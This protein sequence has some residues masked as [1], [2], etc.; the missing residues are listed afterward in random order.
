MNVALVYDRVNKWGGAERVLLALHK[1]WPKA[2]L[3]T[4]VYDPIRAPW[5]DVF[6]VRPSFLQKIPGAT[7]LHE[8]L[9]GL[10]PLAFESFRFD[11]YDVVVSVTSA[12]A[13]DILTKPHTTHIC[14]CLTPTRYLW[15]GFEHYK[16]R[17]GLGRLSVGASLGLKILGPT[18]REW[19]GIAA[20]RPDHYIAISERVKNRI[21]RYY[22]RDTAAVVHPPVDLRRFALRVR[23]ADGKDGYFL[24]V[25]R[26]VSYKRIDVLIEAFNRLGLPLVIIGDGHQKHELMRMAK[27]HIR[28]V[29]RHLTDSELV[30]YYE[31]CRAFVYAADEDFGL[32]V[33]EAQ[34]MGIP[35]IAYR[36]SGV[37]EI[38]KDGVTGVLFSKQSPES[39]A[40][41]VGTFERMTFSPRACRGQVERMSEQVFM[42]RMK[43]L[44]ERLV[45]NN[46]V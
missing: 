17:P 1:L 34:A 3:Y 5:A 30:R 40:T 29:D 11:A 37:A 22:R 46:T 23:R 38:V 20:S 28:F 6:D 27:S 26:L 4:A 32:A 10:T 44:V 35:V 21:A 9:P 19:D 39:L 41:A 18:L 8:S 2:P 36:D 33:A 31:G 42:R 25:S 7:R 45:D 43:S 24:T 16:K 12:E 13:K 15:S 14:Y